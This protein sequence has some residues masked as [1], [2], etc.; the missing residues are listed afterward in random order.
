MHINDSKNAPKTHEALPE[1]I[2]FA[3]KNG[4][5][6]VKISDLINDFEIK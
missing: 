6:F 4:Y 2:K 1:I 5:Q 3:E